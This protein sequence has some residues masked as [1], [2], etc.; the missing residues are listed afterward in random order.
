MGKAIRKRE[1]AQR[2]AIA[3]GDLDG[4]VGKVGFFDTAKYADGTPVAYV[5]SIHEFGAAEQGIP[6][7]PFFRP[8]IAER[9]AEW[10]KQFGQG[11][12]AVAKG[13]FTA[14][15]VMDAVGLGAAGDVAK[16]IAGITTP[17]LKDATIAARRRR[18]AN[19]KLGKKTKG[20]LAKPLVDTAVMVNSVTHIV[21][22]TGS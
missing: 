20:N 8:T 17:P 19:P 3:V 15:Q 10:T 1:G 7:R 21:E 13:T 22:R 9:S 4:L 6:P 12:R 5:A 2:L 11:A 18:Y 16:T 14:S